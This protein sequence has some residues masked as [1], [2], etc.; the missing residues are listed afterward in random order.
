M[1]NHPIRI[2]LI[3]PNAESDSATSE[4]QQCYRT[5]LP[6]LQNRTLPHLHS[7]LM[8]DDDDDDDDDDARESMSKIEHCAAL[9][10]ANA[11]GLPKRGLSKEHV[12]V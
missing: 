5:W 10:T 12:P 9:W 1:S 8:P 4:H 11:K 2:R 7:I 3:A 6:G